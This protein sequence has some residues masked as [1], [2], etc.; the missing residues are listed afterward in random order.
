[1]ATPGTRAKFIRS[2]NPLEY[3]ESR[4]WCARHIE[5]TNSTGTGQG[6]ADLKQLIAEI[7]RAF[8]ANGDKDFTQWLRSKIS[9]VTTRPTQVLQSTQKGSRKENEGG[10]QEKDN[11]LLRD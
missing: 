2:L 4:S 10:M 11:T 8:V 6:F 5:Y 7:C 3:S 9:P 1:L